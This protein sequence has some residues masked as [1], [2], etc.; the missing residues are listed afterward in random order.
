MDSTTIP[1][2]MVLVGMVLAAV[3]GV[4]HGLLG[5]SM[6]A[7]AWCGAGLFVVCVLVLWVDG[8]RRRDRPPFA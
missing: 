3:V 6:A 2:A 4:L 5:V 7:I 8:R 1:L